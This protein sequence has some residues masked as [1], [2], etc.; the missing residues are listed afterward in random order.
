MSFGKEQEKCCLGLEDKGSRCKM[1]HQDYKTTREWKALN[2]IW[3]SSSKEVQQSCFEDFK[4]ITQMIQINY[5]HRM[6]TVKDRNDTGYL[7]SLSEEAKGF[8]HSH[9]PNLYHSFM[10][11]LDNTAF[12]SEEE[13]IGYYLKKYR[14]KRPYLEEH[15][16]LVREVASL[17]FNR[18]Q[19]R[20]SEE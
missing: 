20:H 14:A 9:S 10:A 11:V 8:V 6:R 3:K 4:L 5:S 17:C 7:N 12:D 19:R 15:Q 1:N 2:H 13:L 16:E 18:Y